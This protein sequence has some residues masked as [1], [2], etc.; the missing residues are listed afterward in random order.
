[1]AKEVAVAVSAICHRCSLS[2]VRE[3]IVTGRGSLP[4]PLLFIGEAPSSTEDMLGEAYMGP[5]GKLLE[6]IIDQSGYRGAWYATNTVHC[7]PSDKRHGESREPTGAEILTCMP[8]VMR[9][10]DECKPRAVV[11]LG[12]VA[13]RYYER[14]IAQTRIHLLHP[15]ALLR[16]GG[17]AS[18]SFMRCVF[19]LQSFLQREGLIHASQET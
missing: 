16:T 17:R 1:M 14:Q 10:I 6:Q 15:A 13:F 3:N 4:A 8:R 5:T 19:T 9:I 7:H 2:R 18:P 11:L 12:Q